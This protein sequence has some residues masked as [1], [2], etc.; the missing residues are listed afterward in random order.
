MHHYTDCGLRNVY[1]KNGY[2]KIDTPY[3]K[4][5]VIEDLDGLYRAIGLSLVNHKPR[6]SGSEV[7]YL[8]VGLNLSQHDLAR[9]LGVAE[10]SVRGWE[11]HRT[12]ITKPA[13]RLLRALYREHVAGDGSIRDMVEA[14]NQL[15]QKAYERKLELETTNAGWREVA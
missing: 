1:L 4:G 8:R 3:G 10:T 12:K 15:N 14:L 13:E 11:N 6:L 2:Q 7:R 9:I 5:V